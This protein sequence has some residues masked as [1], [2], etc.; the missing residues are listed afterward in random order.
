MTLPLGALVL[1]CARDRI[2]LSSRMNLSIRVI[3]NFKKKQLQVA[4]LLH[5]CETKE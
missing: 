5:L 4:L 2:S 3:T 1:P